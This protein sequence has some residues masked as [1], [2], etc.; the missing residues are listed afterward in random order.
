MA[1]R[2]GQLVL[3]LLRGKPGPSSEHDDPLKQGLVFSAGA[4]Q[5]AGGYPVF[6]RLAVRGDV[7]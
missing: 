1:Y 4:G 3:R 5:G 6:D 2:M 7:L